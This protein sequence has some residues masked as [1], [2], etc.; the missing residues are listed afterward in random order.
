[1]REI[2]SIVVAAMMSAAGAVVFLILPMLVGFFV[3]LLGFSEQQAG[4][5][6]SAYFAAYFLTGASAFLWVARVNLYRVAWAGYAVMVTGL[7]LAAGAG[8]AWEMAAALA[9][10]GAGSGALFALGVAVIA[11]TRNQDRNFGWVLFAQQLAAAALLLL[12]PGWV[13]PAWGLSGGLLA[14]AVVVAAMSATLLLIPGLPG[15]SQQKVEEIGSRESGSP[16]PRLALVAMVLHFAALSALWAFVERIGAGNGLGSSQVGNA[17]ALSMLG[18]LAG[19][20]A[21]TLLGD[22]LGRRFPLWLAAAAFLVV[23]WGYSQHLAW[24]YFAAFAALL[25]F[26]WNFVLAYQMGIVTG[27]DADGRYAVLIPAA[28]AGGAMAGPALGGLLVSAGGYTLL[29]AVVPL[30]IL[31]ATG[32]FSRLARS[33]TT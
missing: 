1:M 26:A 11:Q 31:A 32:M 6:S 12:I 27:L 3:D 33:I 25:S 23:A 28:Q 8:G 2:K 20:L 29:L 9:L 15:P 5:L 17:L 16:G 24:G 19:A 18:G 4:M 22:R 10:S 21:V 30:G 13:V 7:A 14:I